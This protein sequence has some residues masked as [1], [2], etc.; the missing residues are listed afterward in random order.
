MKNG[1]TTEEIEKE[2]DE[3]SREKITGKNNELDQNQNKL[4]IINISKST[5]LSPSFSYPP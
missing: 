3:G 1:K 2:E 4:G 5:L